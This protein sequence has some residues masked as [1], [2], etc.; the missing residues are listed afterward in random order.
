M[1][2]RL[3][4][5]KRPRPQECGVDL[6]STVAHA[7]QALSSQ[8][9]RPA[10]PAAPP[11]LPPLPHS[12]PPQPPR[13]SSAKSL[14]SLRPPPTLPSLGALAA[15]SPFHALPGLPQLCAASAIASRVQGH[16]A[17]Q[18]QL[19]S[20]A[21]LHRELARLRAKYDDFLMQSL[22]GM[23]MTDGG[24][25]EG[26]SGGGGGGAAA[27]AAAAAAA[28]PPP[29]RSR[30]APPPS[31]ASSA[32]PL[33]L[34]LDGSRSAALREGLE[35]AAAWKA[36]ALRPLPPLRLVEVPALPP[37]TPPSTRA[38]Q[39]ATA[40]AAAASAA[41]ATAAAAAA[42]GA[43]AA[44]AASEAAVAAAAADAAAAATASA[45]ASA[46]AAAAAT[47][48]AAAA[49]AP[50]IDPVARAAEVL[51]RPLAQADLDAL[52]VAMAPPTG[53]PGHVFN[54]VDTLR[55]THDEVKDLRAGTWLRD[56]IVNQFFM[57]LRLAGEAGLLAAAGAGRCGLAAGTVWAHNSFFY[58]KL[59]GQVGEPVYNYSGVKG[60]TA[61][62]GK[63]QATDLFAYRYVIMPVNRGNVHWT[64]A[65]IDN[66]ERTVCFMDSLGGDGSDVE[67]ALLRYVVDEWADKKGCAMPGPPYRAVPAPADLPR[68]HNGVD[69]GAFVC[70][71]GECFLRG[72]APSEDIFTQRNLGFWRKKIGVTVLKGVLL[73]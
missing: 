50:L 3:E 68:Q 42:S 66:L 56:G 23:S 63:R 20:N 10:A 60:W 17:A 32:P 4:H 6:S 51:M 37:A 52:G 30:L 58:A 40:A 14:G 69:C 41:A 31:A 29:P 54:K 27:A 5:L 28:V 36:E 67:E 2:V 62:R 71:F 49:E 70:A 48:A 53:D 64:F 8:H 61:K 7:R 45:S 59:M 22:G 26:S 43:A 35:A 72:V 47:A 9:S 19:Q 18:Q 21:R 65:V 44:A 73:D 33:D 16:E 11:P 12:P 25:D 15:P 57:V 13:A 34:P 24:S 46:S 1:A 39:E 55:V 38:A